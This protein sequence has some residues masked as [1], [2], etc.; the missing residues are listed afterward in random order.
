MG[1]IACGVLLS[2]QHAFTQDQVVAA[3]VRVSEDI[4]MDD[5]D[6]RQVDAPI[7][8]SFLDAADA[9]G[10]CVHQDVKS[11]L[12]R[13]DVYGVVAGAGTELDNL[14]SAEPARNQAKLPVKGV[15]AAKMAA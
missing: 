12:L 9:V 2:I 8:D 15:A 10:I 14:L 6:G 13:S 5:L 11:R 4:L 1:E 3:L 7:G